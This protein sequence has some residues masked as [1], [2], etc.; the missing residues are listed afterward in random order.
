MKRELVAA[1]QMRQ[2]RD[3]HNVLINNDIFYLSLDCVNSRRM[4]C[5]EFAQSSLNNVEIH[6]VIG[7]L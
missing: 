1:T 2:V 5:R 6:D 4:N 7:G 3:L